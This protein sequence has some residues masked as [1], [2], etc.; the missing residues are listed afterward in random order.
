MA[1]RLLDGDLALAVFMRRK[2]LVYFST[3]QNSESVI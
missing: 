3:I 1:E 2:R